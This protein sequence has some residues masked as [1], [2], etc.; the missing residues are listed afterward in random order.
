[1]NS[2]LLAFLFVD[3]FIIGAV[4]AVASRH[5][6]AH[7]RQPKAK[8]RPTQDNNHLPPE[9]RQHLLE[10]SSTRFEKVLDR[11]AVQLETE[12]SKTGEKIDITVKRLAADILTKELDGL[13]SMYD[14]YEQAAGADLAKAKSETDSYHRQL[15]EKLEQAASGEKERLLALIDGQL[16]DSLLSFISETLGQEVDLGSQTPYL[17]T[18]LESHKEEFR[19]AVKG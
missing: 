2:W 6:Y 10:Q 5:A 11:A 9:M 14:R 13:K 7:Y 12:L 19:Q 1:M 18:Q 4:F 15:Q 17:M 8:T 16:A 3:V